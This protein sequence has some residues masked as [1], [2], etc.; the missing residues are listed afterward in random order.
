MQPHS[1]LFSSVSDTLEFPNQV[2]YT[3]LTAKKVKNSTH[4]Q[5]MISSWQKSKMRQASHLLKHINKT[6]KREVVV[7]IDRVPQVLHI[8]L[9]LSRPHTQQRRFHKIKKTMPKTIPDGCKIS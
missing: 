2:F 8:K 4:L 9:L 7:V 3:P 6:F 5:E 1:L